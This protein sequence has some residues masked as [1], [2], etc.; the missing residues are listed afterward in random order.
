MLLE[1]LF[2]SLLLFAIALIAHKSSVNEYEILQH[3]YDGDIQWN[4]L[5]AENLPLVVRNVPKQWI[6]GWTPMKYSNRSY[7]IRVVDQKGKMYDTRWNTWLMTPQYTQLVKTL[8]VNELPGIENVLESIKTDGFI[9]WFYINYIILPSVLHPEYT[10]KI[11]KCIPEYT[12][13]TVTYGSPLTIWLAHEGALANTNL[14]DQNPWTVTSDTVPTIGDVKYIE[15]KLRQGNCFAI[16]KH[17]FYAL[18]NESDSISWYHV[19]ELHSP[20]SK[21]LSLIPSK[22]KN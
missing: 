14:I 10:K 20:L 2:L 17:W 1:I 18:K 9:R 7:K 22:Y 21:I 19:V 3:D 8:S 13:I 11:T 16:P 4:T 15:I 12:L 6:G 5:L